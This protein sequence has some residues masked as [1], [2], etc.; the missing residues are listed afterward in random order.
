MLGT[1]DQQKHEE[2]QAMLSRTEKEIKN[3][4]E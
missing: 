2:E 4:E 1:I 3:L